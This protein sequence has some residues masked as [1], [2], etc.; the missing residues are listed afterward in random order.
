MEHKV[1]S[2]SQESS[3]K[4][5]P[6]AGSASSLQSVQS[7]F[8]SAIK[9]DRPPRRRLILAAVNDG[10]GV[11]VEFQ[12]GARPK[13]TLLGHI[14][15]Q[16]QHL[17]GELDLTLTAS[18]L[19]AKADPNRLLVV[20]GVEAPI[21]TT[22]LCLE[23]HDAQA[24]ARPLDELLLLGL[25]EAGAQ[26]EKVCHH[27]G[28]SSESPWVLV[29]QSAEQLWDKHV[30]ALTKF[31]A[32]IDVR[33]HSGDAVASALGHQILANKVHGC[34]TLLKCRAR[35]D[36]YVEQ[37]GKEERLVA[38]ALAAE[39]QVA[40]GMVRLLLDRKPDMQAM[41]QF[42]GASMTVE[43]ALKN[44]AAK[45]SD[46]LNLA[47]R[48]QLTLDDEK[49]DKARKSDSDADQNSEGGS[50]RSS[51]QE[52]DASDGSD[53]EDDDDDIADD[54]E[55]SSDEGEKI[56]V[57]EE[58]RENAE[59]VVAEKASDKR[60]FRVTQLIKSE[61]E[62]TLAELKALD[63]GGEHLEKPIPLSKLI[64]LEPPSAHESSFA[65]N[66]DYA[67]WDL[68]QGKVHK[69]MNVI[70]GSVN[71]GTSRSGRDRVIEVPKG[72]QLEFE[73]PPHLQYP[74][75]PQYT[76]IIEF[77]M[78]PFEG[79]TAL[80][81]TSAEL[82]EA[83]LVVEGSTSES[84]SP[85]PT[86][87]LRSSGSQETALSAPLSWNSW[88]RIVVT[89]SADGLASLM[90]N[91]EEVLPVYPKANDSSGVQ[92]AIVEASLGTLQ[93]AFRVFGSK[94]AQ[95]SSKGSSLRFVLL[96]REALG[97]SAVQIL[98]RKT[99][100]LMKSIQQQPLVLQ[101]LKLMKKQAHPIFLDA[102]FLGCFCD[103]FTKAD[104]QPKEVVQSHRLILFMFE[105]LIKESQMT[106]GPDVGVPLELLQLTYE[107]LERSSKLFAKFDQ[108][109]ESSDKKEQVPLVKNFLKLLNELRSS[110]A[111]K[112]SDFG[113]LIIP[114]GL[115][116]VEMTRQDRREEEER[117]ETRGKQF[118]LLILE[119][120]D[121]TY[122]LTVV[123]PGQGRE[124]HKSSVQ[125]HPKVKYQTAMVLEGLSREKAEDDA[126][127]LTLFAAVP[128]AGPRSAWHLLYDLFLPFLLGAK[129]GTKM[130][131]DA[132]LS[133]RDTDWRT[134]QHGGGCWKVIMHGIRQLLRSNSVSVANAKLLQWRLRQQFL[135]LALKDVDAA[136]RL[137]HGQRTCLRMAASQLGLAAVKLSVQMPDT[138]GSGFLKE[139][140]QLVEKTEEALA[141]KP[142]LHSGE[143]PLAELQPSALTARAHEQ[144]TAHPN[145]DYFIGPRPNPWQSLSVPAQ[146]P[147]DLLALRERVE[148]VE[149]AIHALYTAKDV[150][151]TLSGMREAGRCKFGHLLI[152]NVLQQLF[153]EIV[154]TPL[155]PASS[156]KDAI[157][158]CHRDF[159]S[160]HEYLTRPM[161]SDLQ[162][163]L[164]ELCSQF[165]AAAF[166]IHTVRVNKAD[167]DTDAEVQRAHPSRT[168][169]STILCIFGAIA[170]LSDRLAR[171]IPQDHQSDW[172][173]KARKSEESS[174]GLPPVPLSRVTQ[175]LVGTEDSPGFAI[176]IDT[177]VAQSETIEVAIPAL[178][179]S[180]SAVINYFE[181]VAESMDL[182][183]DPAR[184]LFDW[185]D[186][187]WQMFSYA[188]YG[189]SVFCRTLAASYLPAEKLLTGE[190]PH[191]MAHFPDF[192]AFRDVIFWFKYALCTDLTVFPQGSFSPHTASLRWEFEG[193][194]Y[195][196]S[197]LCQ[198]L[199]GGDK[200]VIPSVDGRRWPSS[201]AAS[202]HTHSPVQREDDL[203]YMRS[204]LLAF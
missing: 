108:L 155:G 164:L 119:K 136:P 123:N 166:S 81:H 187:N 163:S 92:E 42:E 149:E 5:K 25:G 77:Q 86:L 33:F 113:P 137:S 174:S 171:M 27:H 110:L 131:E 8:E 24:M 117:T 111:E 114:F 116:S 50:S 22:L 29:L 74:S 17:Q 44:L 28:P 125:G 196:V 141:A 201:A 62:E 127:W 35:P 194:R 190:E 76:A 83:E 47:A 135:Q 167:S 200:Q 143:L 202:N 154:P 48:V 1:H 69:S 64:A 173:D 188:H 49:S 153:T 203:L 12:V 79:I 31:K 148:T 91:G 55:K 96:C 3:P 124:F 150:C 158:S 133:S 90:V 66:K 59:V 170:A 109:W 75:R 180:R 189:T 130:L 118:V 40:L 15:L 147:L 129:G 99:K 7:E 145:W 168:F 63:G 104:S 152:V 106:K 9:Q 179:M 38:V 121:D 87:K 58:I 122:R 160:P 132:L 13:T 172:Q 78:K 72:T 89:R 41:I 126:F 156:H 20:D 82:G 85:Q 197:G 57:P 32:D 151:R 52:G 4:G 61:G 162:Q 169:D 97:A 193:G 112:G 139:A 95:E 105:T 128:I 10:L 68:H 177:F 100:Q 198:T 204:W 186:G 67:F 192:R 103:G 146:I 94:H 93:S 16:A 144:T 88:R 175:T 102:S 60:V 80:L 134:P 34:K 98:L 181:E 185:E 11:N 178:H 165:A 2:L 26:G 161:V 115:H 46:W 14:C 140:K 71:V 183:G 101:E 138:D 107:H 84:G 37:S 142:V 157:W 65:A 21:A 43:T 30:E 45:D 18:L 23:I 191:L 36:S 199:L 70:G 73:P 6:T 51:D 159:N 176:L 39:K 184:I 54:A 56:D 53:E 120:P 182:Q 19:R 195:K